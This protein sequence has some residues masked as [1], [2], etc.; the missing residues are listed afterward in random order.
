MQ[1]KC[2][3]NLI[4]YPVVKWNQSCTFQAVTW[5]HHPTVSW[6]WHSEH[7]WVYLPCCSAVVDTCICW[8]N[9]QGIIIID[10]PLCWVKYFLLV[11]KY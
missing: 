8:L 6:Q 2:K 9:E 5:E 11:Y 10:M 4:E 3:I 1:N 7:L